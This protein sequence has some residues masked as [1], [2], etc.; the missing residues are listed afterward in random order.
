MVQLSDAA[1]I[2][3][4]LAKPD[5]FGEL[6]DRHMPEIRRYLHR[7]VGVAEGDDLTAECFAVAFRGRARYDG[8]RA[9]AR[10]WLFG[11]AANLIRNHR[12]S[13]VRH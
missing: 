5:R 2:E 12:R 7:R 11:I 1:L 13:E 10:P 4:S 3:A 8:S 6:F 9:D